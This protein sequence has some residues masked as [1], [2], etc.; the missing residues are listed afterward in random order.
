LSLDWHP[1]KVFSSDEIE[2]SFKTS[3]V[4]LYRTA[5]MTQYSDVWSL[6]DDSKPFMIAGT[7]GEMFRG[8]RSMRLAEEGYSNIS[9]EEKNREFLF[10]KELIL[11]KNYFTHDA[12]EYYHNKLMDTFRSFDELYSSGIMPGK[13]ENIPSSN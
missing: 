10:N 1:P 12:W 13:H 3:L 5:G 4:N 6:L 11:P 8:Y 7:A 9:L 2:S